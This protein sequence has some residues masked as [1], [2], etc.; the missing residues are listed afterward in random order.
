M[1]EESDENTWRVPVLE[2]ELSPPRACKG[3]ASLFHCRRKPFTLKIDH[4]TMLK[5][6]TAQHGIVTPFPKSIHTRS[7]KR[8]LPTIQNA[9][10]PVTRM[11]LEEFWSLA[12]P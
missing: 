2:R 1:A 10:L 4:S 6:Y 5:K 7:T 8:V 11:I 9:Y 12:L 3:S